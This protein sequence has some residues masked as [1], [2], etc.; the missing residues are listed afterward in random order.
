MNC[1]RSIKPPL[2]SKG[3]KI[4]FTVYKDGKNGKGSHSSI[5]T[6]NQIEKLKAKVADVLA[7]LETAK[8]EK[9]RLEEEKAR[10]GED[11]EAQRDMNATL[12]SGMRRLEEAEADLKSML[13]SEEKKSGNYSSVIVELE[14]HKDS[15]Q[16]RINALEDELRQMQEGSARLEGQLE[17]KTLEARH[18]DEIR[19]QTEE[20]MNDVATVNSSLARENQNLHN[21]L[22]ELAGEY[23]DIEKRLEALAKSNAET[24]EKL[25]SEKERADKLQAEIDSRD[26]ERTELITELQRLRGLDDIKTFERLSNQFEVARKELEKILESNTS[27]RKENSELML[28]ID[29]LEEEND[30]LKSRISSLEDSIVTLNVALR[31][32]TGEN[33]RLGLS[34]QAEQ[35]KNSEAKEK[36]TKLEVQVEERDKAISG[37]KEEIAG[38]TADNDSLKG[39]VASLHPD[40]LRKIE[41]EFVS[42]IT[43]L[44]KKEE[45]LEGKKSETA[46]RISS[47]E[48]FA[49]K[50]FP[51]HKL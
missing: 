42:Q 47:L 29:R 36:I 8:K 26:K 17:Q 51:A 39:Q 48:G 20:R 10:F 21:S 19:V 3:R 6:L 37:M 46:K 40:S 15:L 5:I 12:V 41:Q 34:L 43:D 50:P 11:L 31:M 44:K 25:A 23:K 32:A 45:L 22:G 33:K 35:G 24:N 2:K 14:S 7:K 28:K 16:K 9:A 27:Y 38:I 4:D 49:H 30:D 18:F 1:T 13:A